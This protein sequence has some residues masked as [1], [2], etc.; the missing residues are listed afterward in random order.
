MGSF[1]SHPLL[2]PTFFFMAEWSLPFF[3]SS[4]FFPSYFSLFLALFPF[5]FPLFSSFKETCSPLTTRS[6]RRT[7]TR[8]RRASPRYGSGQRAGNGP[9]ELTL[10]GS[11]DHLLSFAHIA[12]ALYELQLNSEKLAQYL[13]EVEICSA[14]VRVV[15]N[16]KERV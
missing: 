8:S 4:F 13:R 1:Q 6:R 9:Q 2:N 12:Q 5:F 16:E 14:K 3:S 15:E 11:P 10:V 7:L